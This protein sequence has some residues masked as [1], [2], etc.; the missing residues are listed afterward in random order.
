MDKQAQETILYEL[1]ME[2]LDARS[3]V[4]RDNICNP[5]EVACAVAMRKVPGLSFERD[6][7]GKHVIKY[8]TSDNPTEQIYEKPVPVGNWSWIDF[9]LYDG[10]LLL[11]RERWLAMEHKNTNEPYNLEKSIS[12]CDSLISRLS[13]VGFSETVGF[14]Y[15]DLEAIMKMRDFLRSLKEGN[16]QHT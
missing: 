13:L 5:T 1:D 16:I 10:N 3:I 11:D 7:S 8:V 14:R 4:R 15:S 9:L 2:I 12:L 6:T